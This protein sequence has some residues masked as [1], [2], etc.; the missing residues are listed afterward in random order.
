MNLATNTLLL[1]P[2]AQT[3]LPNIEALSSYAH[4][5]AH[6]T[7]QH[8]QAANRHLVK[9]ILCEFTHEKLISPQ[10][11]AQGAKVNHY[12]L[13]L[14]DC[15]YYFSARHYQ[16]DH[17]DIATDSIRVSSAGQD[18]PLDAMSLIIQLKDALGMSETLLPTYLEEITS[19][20]YSKAYKLAHQ[21]IPAATLAKADYQT[22][23]A[24]MTEGHPVFIA[25]NGRI[26]FDMQ[27]YYQ[28]APESASALQLVWIA[29]RKDKTT[30]SALE[31]LDHDSLLKQELGE[32]FTEFQQHLSALGQA[33]DS[34]YFMPV[35]PWQWR[36][37]IARTFAGEIARGDIIY[38]GESQDCYQ[39][40]QSIR[41][42]FNLSAPQKCYVKTALSILNMGFMRGLSPLYMSCTPQINAWVA[43][44]IESDSYFAEQG[45]VILKE[46]AAIGYHHR[47]YEEA[48]TQD[49][50]YK[51][52]L[53]ALW[54]ESPLPH[55]EPQQTL[56][57][58]AALL[59]V[60]HQEQALLAAL[61][62]DSGL[63]AKEWVKRYLK[64]YLS[65]LLHAFFA[66][67]LV[68][69]PH[70]ENLI[71]VLDAGIPVKILMKDIGEEVAVL[72]GSEPL[73]KEVQRL[74][75][76]LE[77]DMKLNYILLDIFDCIF[78]YLA[79]ILDKQTAVSEA[80]FWE[81]VADNVRDYQAQH[82][83]LADKFAQYDLFK[84]SFVR[85]CLNR[86][87]LNNNQQMIDLADREKN[88]RFAGGLDN[89][90]A[91]FRQSHAIGSANK[92]LKP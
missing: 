71:L 19:T 41:T 61:I 83:H 7:P 92:K 85:T 89:P 40:Q 56:M 58:M 68:F 13:R 42:F 91:A 84:D 70:G 6:L 44:L 72:N 60:D 47:Y 14:N 37:K 51:K 10:I 22:I 69:M 48:L 9:K 54:R 50:A 45:F 1:K 38:L 24:G 39:V 11:Y 4:V 17:L 33:A 31:G 28:F 87:Q 32:Q 57:T 46:I 23:E 49:S 30:F 52:M 27:D 25:N 8:W 59:H 75:V 36:E 77:E 62:A 79:P 3:E 34:F 80:L 65:P 76:A 21:A 82:P 5:P 90:L 29:V 26:G 16:L 15:T 78:R 2:F 35:H 81:L 12:E 64:L 88:L 73:P 67:D 18:K 66:Y 63:S 20:L 74:A 43:K 53:S 86:I 55:I